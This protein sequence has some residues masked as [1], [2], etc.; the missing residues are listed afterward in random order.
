M[1]IPVVSGKLAFDESNEPFFIFQGVEYQ[2]ADK[3]SPWQT[4]AHIEALEWERK[5]QEDTLRWWQFAV[6]HQDN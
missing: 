2:D 3:V 4:F 1:I 5:S 6:V